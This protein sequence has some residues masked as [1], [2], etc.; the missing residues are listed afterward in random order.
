MDLFNKLNGLLIVADKLIE[1]NALRNSVEDFDDQD[2]VD[3]PYQRNNFRKNEHIFNAL[4]RQHH[5]DDVVPRDFV[6]INVD[7]RQQG[8]AGFDSWGDQVLVE[9]SILMS[10]NHSYGFT[11]IPANDE[12]EIPEKL[13]HFYT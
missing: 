5:I 8:L 7:L 4:R 3:L 13:T 6:E 11:I 1:F 9:D 10:E 2:Q 12:N